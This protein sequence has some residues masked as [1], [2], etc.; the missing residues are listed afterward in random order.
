VDGHDFASM[1][2]AIEAAKRPSGKPTMIILDTVKGKGCSFCEGQSASH[3]MTIT[4]EQAKEAIAAL[5]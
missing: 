2:A 3:N 5:G 4:P 1:D